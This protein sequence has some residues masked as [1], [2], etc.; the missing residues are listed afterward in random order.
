VIALSAPVNQ[1]DIVQW[2]ITSFDVAKGVV[3]A[4]FEAASGRKWID[5]TCQ[6]S[7]AA[8]A[9]VGAGVHT[10]GTDWDT[11]IWNLQGVGAANS[12][13]AAR[14]AYRGGATNAAGLQAVELRAQTDGWVVGLSGTAA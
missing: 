13:T 10:G 2:H 12:L 11:R 1:D 3:V 5:V 7:D 8:N 9:S 6:L 14:A 4:R